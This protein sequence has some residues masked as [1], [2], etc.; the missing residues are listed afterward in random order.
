MTD[1]LDQYL[2]RDYPLVLAVERTP[3][4]RER[5]A[6]W[7]IDLPGCIAQGS[8][9]M[10][11]RD[12]LKAVMPAYILALISKG[13]P[14]PQPTKL[15]GIIPGLVGFYDSRTGHVLSADPG[16]IEDVQMIGA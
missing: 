13:V 3:D 7:P 16:E 14:I 2:A 4:G 11:T 9:R 6:A 15:P 8:S 5:F 10:E 12:R 1:N